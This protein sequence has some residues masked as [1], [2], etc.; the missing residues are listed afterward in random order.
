MIKQYKFSGLTALL[1]VIFPAWVQ[2]S[3]ELDEFPV[4]DEMRTYTVMENANY[5]GELMSVIGFEADLSSSEVRRYYQRYWSGSE[6]QS[7]LGQWQQIS[8]VTRHCILTVQYQASGSGK[9][10]GRLIAS[11]PPQSQQQDMGKG[12]P[13]PNDGIVISDLDTQDGPKSGRLVMISSEASAI[14]IVDFY[15]AE[16]QGTRWLLERQFEDQGASVMLFRDGLD[17]M[18]VVVIPTGNGMSQILI[19]EI[20]TR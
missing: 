3:C 15:R 11:K 12:L 14:D 8:T 17:E 9:T 13:V 19:N 6:V 18:N 16:L 10:A 2:A 4:M 20:N 1:F 5:N 7:E